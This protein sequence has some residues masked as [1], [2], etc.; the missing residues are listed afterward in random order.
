MQEGLDALARR[1]GGLFYHDR[2]DIPECIRQATDDQL[3][4]YLLGYSPR[5]GTFEKDAAKAKFHRVVVRMRLPGLTVRWK[6]GFNG[7]T[8]ELTTALPSGAP[9]TRERQL[10]DALASPFSATGLK[11]RLTSLFNQ[12]KQSGALVQSLL[13]FGGKELAFQHEADGTWHAAVDVVTSAYRGVPRAIGLVLEG[14]FLAAEMQQR[15][16]Q[17]SALLGLVEEGSQPDLE[18]GGAEG[19]GQRIQQLPLPGFGRG[20]GQRGSEF[21]GHAVEPAL[22]ADRQPGQPH[23]DH[24]A[25]KLRLGGVLLERAFARRVAQQV[26]AELIVG[27]LVDAFW[28]VVVVVVKEPAGA[29][30]QRVQAFLHAEIGIVFAGKRREA[31]QALGVGTIDPDILVAFP[32]TRAQAARVDGVEGYGG[33]V[34]QVRDLIEGGIDLAIHPHTI[35]EED[36]CLAAGQLLHPLNH[37]FDGAERAQGGHGISVI[38]DLRLAPLPVWLR[39]GRQWRDRNQPGAA[40]EAPLHQIDGFQQDAPVGGELLED[41]DAAAGAHQRYQIAGL[42]LAFH[43]LAERVANADQVVEGE[44]EIVHHQGYAAPHLRGGDGR[45]RANGLFGGSRFG[46]GA[47]RIGCGYRHGTGDVREIGELLRHA[48]L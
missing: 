38:E 36:D 27:G 14:E 26:I 32:G 33:S 6:S 37:L 44:G 5:E 20:R 29:S 10:L 48:V 19:R 34:G 28:E 1:T 12:T 21:V 42:H 13:H 43:V 11:V 4:Y 22:P 40:G 17:C 30:G 15:L 45:G 2:N 46:F 16:N 3:G 41:G 25:M 18:P 39:A 47:G 35:G 31:F 7:V 8:D 23:A 9:K 24:H